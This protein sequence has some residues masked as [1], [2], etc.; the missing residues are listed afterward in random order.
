MFMLH[1]TYS[2]DYSYKSVYNYSFIGGFMNTPFLVL[3]DGHRELSFYR[4]D[5]KSVYLDQIDRDINFKQTLEIPNPD[6]FIANLR[7]M[8]Y[9]EK[10][11]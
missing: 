11:A 6:N 3:V 10:N 9:K 1:V 5:D 7:D 4:R 2:V 8:G